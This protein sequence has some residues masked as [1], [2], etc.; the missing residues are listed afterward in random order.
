MEDFPEG[1]WVSW[2]SKASKDVHQLIIGEWYEQGFNG[3]EQDFTQ[4]VKHYLRAVDLGNIDA[5]ASLGRCYDTGCGV[6]QDSTMAVKYYRQAADQGDPE[7]QFLLGESY[8]LGLGVEQ[9]YA[10]AAMYYKQAASVPRKY[11]AEAQV[12]LGICYE[13]GQ[14]VEQDFAQAVKYFRL[15]ADKDCPKAYL[16]LSGCYED[17]QGVKQNIKRSEEYYQYF[18]KSEFE[19]LDFDNAFELYDAGVRYEKGRGVEQDFAMADWF[20]RN[21]YKKSGMIEGK[22]RSEYIRITKLKYHRCNCGC[23]ALKKKMPK[24][25]CCGA[26][27]STREHQVSDWATHAKI[28]TKW[29]LQALHP[30]ENVD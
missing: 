13:N 18:L 30:I 21:A 24:A 28:C 11:M 7:G 17:G 26:R 5:L 4:G 1:T 8:A 19:S 12:N 27:Y 9:D 25:S 16:Y 22:E 3:V 23:G 20:Y 2:M 14:G 6:K 29:S 10:K 15:A